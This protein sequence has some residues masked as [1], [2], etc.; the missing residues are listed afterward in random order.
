[1][2]KTKKNKGFAF[3]R[4]AT[5][6]QAKRDCIELKSPVVQGS[7]VVFRQVRKM[8]R[9]LASIVRFIMILLLCVP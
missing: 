1:M 9:R 5:L 7:N 6:E 4:F 8:M 2:L 3:L